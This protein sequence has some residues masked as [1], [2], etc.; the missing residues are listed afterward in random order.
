MPKNVVVWPHD[1]SINRL[2]GDLSTCMAAFAKDLGATVSLVDVGVGTPTGNLRTE[3]A[4]SEA[5]FEEAFRAGRAAVA[6]GDADLLVLGEMG[7]GNTTPAA[8][9]AAAICGGDPAVW[10]GP[11]TG[12]AGSQ[13]DHKRTVV[14]EAIGRIAAID[15][16]MEVLRQV[17]GA[18]LVAMAGAAVEARL[19]SIPVILDGYVATAALLPLHEVVPGSLDHVLAGHRSPEPGHRWLLDRF[20]KEPLLDLDLR[21]GE[22]SGALAA[23]PLVRLAIAG[24]LNVAT[25]SEAGLA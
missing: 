8:A 16:P 3:P 2:L 5:R 17:G 15:D 6:K 22:G 20:G 23:L 1:G 19:R 7:I 12:V 10:V 11:G 24:V 25:F 18:E 9:V 14:T 21:L 13:L 4:L